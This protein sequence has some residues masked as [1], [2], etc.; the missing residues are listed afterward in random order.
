MERDLHSAISVVA[1]RHGGVFLNE[2]FGRMGP[3][4]NA[5][6]LPPDAIFPLASLTKPITATA[7]MILVEEGVL[8]LNRP[9]QK[10]IP[11][12]EGKGKELI[13]IRHLM[14]HTSGLRAEDL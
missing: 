13:T 10:Y 14:T 2:A 3:E 12:F 6:A 9:V 11:E 4:K 7:V 8:G 5:A 1:A